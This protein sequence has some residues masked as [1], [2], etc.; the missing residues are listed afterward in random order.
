MATR[1]TEA[2]YLC[3]SGTGH[4]FYNVDNNTLF[5]RRHFSEIPISSNFIAK[6]EAWAKRDGM[7]SL[8]IENKQGITLLDSASI[9][10]VE[11]L[12]EEDEEDNQENNNE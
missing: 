6:I 2:M 12:E 11:K 1:A 5:T 4:L 9:A 3:P 8:K 10:G 7:N